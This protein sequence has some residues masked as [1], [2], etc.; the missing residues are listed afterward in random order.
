MFM[1]D[2]NA[3]SIIWRGSLYANH[4]VGEEKLNVKGWPLKLISVL[5][6][7]SSL[8]WGKIFFPEQRQTGIHVEICIEGG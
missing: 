6:I 5:S 4:L 8:K 7:S 1:S 2:F 3:K